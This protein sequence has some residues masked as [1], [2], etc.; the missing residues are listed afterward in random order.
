MND[1]FLQIKLLVD[2][3]LGK[4]TVPGALHIAKAIPGLK[5]RATEESDNLG[6]IKA[7]FTEHFEN[8]FLLANPSKS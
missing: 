6:I 8:N 7:A 2:P 5:G 3:C 4:I 1:L